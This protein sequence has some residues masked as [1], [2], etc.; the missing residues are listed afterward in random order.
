MDYD[1]LCFPRLSTFQQYHLKQNISNQKPVQIHSH[2]QMLIEF[3]K[4]N[5]KK[6]VVL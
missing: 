6:N 1:V 5:Q 4:N 2:L 3:E